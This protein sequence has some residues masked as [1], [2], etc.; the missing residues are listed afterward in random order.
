MQ[1]PGQQGLLLNLSA[2]WRKCSGVTWKQ[3]KKTNNKTKPTKGGSKFLKFTK[4]C[5]NFQ[6]MMFEYQTQR[7]LKL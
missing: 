7:F 6:H 5:E 4:N 2:N 3:N 1:G